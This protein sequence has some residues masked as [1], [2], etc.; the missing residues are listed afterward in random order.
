MPKITLSSV[1]LV[2]SFQSQLYAHGEN[3]LGPNGGFISMP[4][5]FHTEIV[6][7]DES[8]FKVFLLD[9]DFKKPTANESSSVRAIL[10]SKTHSLEIVCKPRDIFFSCFL[11]KKQKMANFHQIILNTSRDGKSGRPVIYEIP[12]KLKKGH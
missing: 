1:V 11:P 7:V 9:M 8:N 10:K 5:L 2:I 3:K 6:E 12:L 4:G